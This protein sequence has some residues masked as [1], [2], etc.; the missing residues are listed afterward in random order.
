[1]YLMREEAGALSSDDMDRNKV[2][3]QFLLLSINYLVSC[4]IVP[5]CQNF[6]YGMLN[7]AWNCDER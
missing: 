5:C 7:L 2:I 4:H 3:D 6:M 1:M